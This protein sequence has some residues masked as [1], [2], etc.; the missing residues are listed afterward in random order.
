M[1]SYQH[2]IY[3]QERDTAVSIP[4]QS[5][6][7]IAVAVGTAP[8]NL[9]DNPVANKPIVV[10]SYDEAVAAVG[11][12][13]NW[14]SYTLC[15]V[16]RAFFREFETGPLVLINV[17][18][19]SI[20]KS[21]SIT[22]LFNIVSKTVKIEVEGIL[23]DNNFIVKDDTGTT[24]YIKGTDY[25]VAF[26]S[27]GFP[28]ITIVDGGAI[29]SSETQLDVSYTK[30]D[31]SKVTIDDI[32]GSYNSTTNVY[33]GI[34]CITQVYPMFN[35]VPGILLAPGWSQH[36][37]VELALKAKSSLINGSFNS[38]FLVD[39]DSA[40]ARTRGAAISWKAD[41]G[42]NDKREVV[43]WP[44]I[45][46]QDKVYWFSAYLA[47][48]IVYMDIQNNDVPFKSPSNKKITMSATVLEDGTEVYLDQM[49][50][51]ELNGHGIVTAVNIAG[52]RTWGNNT[53]IYPDS[54][55]PKDR[56]IAVRRVFDWWG[57]SFIVDFFDK[58]DDPTDYRLI[59]SI[60]DEENIKANGYQAVGQIAGAK[61]SFNQKDNPINNILNGKIIFKQSIGAFTPA[62]NIVNILEFDPTMISTALFGGD[63]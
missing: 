13:D 19:S 23:L 28:V 10:T 56:F 63:N 54:S 49:Q 25:T 15:Q 58:V 29:Q 41:K 5:L 47:A 62:E 36:R 22:N 35:L 2:G 3:I 9:V 7:N 51:N 4:K 40:E 17:L 52:W 60:V 14:E 38:L 8:V 26:G 55:D 21:S 24:T 53:G 12:S 31:P 37:D 39:I 61:I 42:Y 46:I 44:K 45:K 48:V 1:S 43:L 50:A 34:E 57:N 30:L 32:I 11:Y 59:E 20:H 16:I 33:K 6:A 27:D 18:D